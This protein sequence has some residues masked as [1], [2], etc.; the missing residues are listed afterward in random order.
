M[1]F[2]SYTPQS[3]LANFVELFWYFEGYGQESSRERVLPTGD[4]QLVISLCDAPL[5]T[6]EGEDG[7]QLLSYRGPLM[8][9]PRSKF[10]IIDTAPLGS[11]MGVQ[12]KP[13]GAFP[14]LGASA[15]E[16]HNQNV[17][18]ESLWGKDAAELRYQ[19]LEAKTPRRRF[20]ILEQ[21]L[22]AR[23]F[24]V[25]ER[26]PAV[27]YALQAFQAVPHDQTIA[28][29]TERT[30]LSSRWLIELFRAQVGLTP[31]LYCRLRRFQSAVKLISGQPDADLAGLAN[32]CGYFDQ[33]HFNRD[34][35]E[36]AGISPTK[37]LADQCEHQNHVRMA[38]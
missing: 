15:G 1:N 7:E 10:S 17:P 13:G 31:K 36:F 34:F 37:Y 27:S 14:F 9:G 12:F 8:C 33:A 28:E 2:L 20:E 19:L 6:Y 24:P 16:L 23:A 3:P 35:R 4:A 5:R 30:G 22:L 21:A 26:H 32:T 38:D 18:L 25:M 29:V 11:S